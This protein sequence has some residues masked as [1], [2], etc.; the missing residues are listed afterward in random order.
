VNL[1]PVAEL[2]PTRIDAA[3]A[4]NIEEDESLALKARCC[5]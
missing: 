3:A 2:T 4:T 1:K 5:I